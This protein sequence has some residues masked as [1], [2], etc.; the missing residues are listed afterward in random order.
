MLPKSYQ[1]FSMLPRSPCATKRS[2]TNS[3]FD[4]LTAGAGTG[5]DPAAWCSCCWCW[6]CCSEQL[7][8]HCCW[9]HC[10]CYNC[11]CRCRWRTRASLG[12]TPQFSRDRNNWSMAA[13]HRQSVQNPRSRATMM[14]HWPF[15]P[16]CRQRH[17]IHC[18][19][20][21]PPRPPPTAAAAAAAAAAAG[22]SVHLQTPCVTGANKDSEAAATAEMLPKCYLK[23][24]MLPN[25]T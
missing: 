7:R 24:T 13:K 20:P 4:P 25:A 8:C 10:R 16:H 11:W 6:C 17:R 19:P 2:L 14:R 5:A 3:T 23:V 12:A 18:S 21:R 1:C 9:C 15:W 22:A